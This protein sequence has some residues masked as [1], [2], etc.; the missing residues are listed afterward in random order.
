MLGK[1]NRLRAWTLAVAV[2]AGGVVAT[3]CADDGLKVTECEVTERGSKGKPTSKDPAKTFQVGDRYKRFH[4]CEP[5]DRE[6]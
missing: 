2:A 6:V 5:G 4:E 1:H 3:A